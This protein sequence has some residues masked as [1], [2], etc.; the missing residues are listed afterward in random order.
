MTVEERIVNILSQSLNAEKEDVT[1]ESKIIA[2]LGAESIDFLD[3]TFRIEREFAIQIPRD[4]LFPDGIFEGDPACVKDGK[5]TPHGVEK[6]QA[7]APHVT[8]KDVDGNLT[9]DGTLHGVQDA[10]TVKS[11]VN[12]VNFK[13]KDKQ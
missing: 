7:A 5:I 12:Y 13:L 3:I 2:D 9:F 8:F 6:L 11:L 1:P 4:E 10:F